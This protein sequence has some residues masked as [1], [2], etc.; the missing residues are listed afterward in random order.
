MTIGSR[1]MTVG[2]GGAG[3][4][5]GI[6]SK[7]RIR[8][9]V[10]DSRSF[11]K[12]DPNVLGFGDEDERM[13]GYD[14]EGGVQVRTETIQWASSVRN[15]GALSEKVV[16]SSTGEGQKHLDGHGLA[17]TVSLDLD[18][19]HASDDQSSRGGVDSGRGRGRREEEVYEMDD[20]SPVKP[21]G[22]NPM[23]SQSTKDGSAYYF[24]AA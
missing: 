9:L 7:A 23:P 5:N 18:L 15:V 6:T 4:R 17:P 2:G 20:L 19:D 11:D 3:S 1:K 24:Y 22:D 13:G 21:E 14:F 16:S 8:S 10:G 12:T